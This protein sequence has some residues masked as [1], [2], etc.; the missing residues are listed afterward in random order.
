[1]YLLQLGCM[2]VLVLFLKPGADCSFLSGQVSERLI[3]YQHMDRE[4]IGWTAE[5]SFTFTTSSPPAALGPEEFH[6]TISYEIT[7]RHSCLLANTGK[8]TKSYGQ[9]LIHNY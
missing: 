4:N 6:I 1:M 7:G 2:L 9:W 3:L 5:D 8:G